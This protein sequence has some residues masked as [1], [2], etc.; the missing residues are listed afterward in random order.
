MKVIGLTKRDGQPKMNN[1]KEKDYSLHTTKKEMETHNNIKHHKTTD[2]L[3]IMV[4]TR[5]VLLKDLNMVAHKWVGVKQSR[6]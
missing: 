6:N 5:E 2:L 3:Q 4:E 1:L